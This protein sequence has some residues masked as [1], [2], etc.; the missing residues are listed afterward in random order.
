MKIIAYRIDDP[1]RPALVAVFLSKPTERTLAGYRDDGWRITALCDHAEIDENAAVVEQISD[2]AETLDNLAG[3]LQLPMPAPM[4]VTQLR[5][6]LPELRDSV[7]SIYTALT[8][9]NPWITHP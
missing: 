6:R 5:G 3:A 8:G 2:V 1:R 7:R 4:H 9:N